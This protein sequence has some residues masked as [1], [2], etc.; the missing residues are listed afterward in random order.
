M[1][2]GLP[3]VPA[4]FSWDWGQLSGMGGMQRGPDPQQVCLFQVSRMLR[5]GPG[6]LALPGS[7]A[8]GT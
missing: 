7:A 5:V 3:K 2:R 4:P 8:H 1:P 6:L